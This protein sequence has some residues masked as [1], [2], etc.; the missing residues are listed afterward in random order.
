MRPQKEYEEVN[1]RLTRE[2]SRLRDAHDRLK[3]KKK[4]T[5]EE[6]GDMEALAAKADRA[7]KAVADFKEQHPEMQRKPRDAGNGWTR[8]TSDVEEHARQIGAE[9]RDIVDGA[10]L[11]NHVSSPA[12]RAW[13]QLGDKFG[14]VLNHRSSKGSD[15]FLKHATAA[16][17]G[18]I[19]DWSW[20]ETDKPAVRG[21]TK[22]NVRFQLQV[23][24]N[25][26]RTGGRDVTAESTE[27]LKQRFNLRE[28]QSGNWVLRD[29]NSAKFH[30]EQ[31]AAAFA[32]LADMVG[33][34]DAQ[35]SLNGRLA[36]AFGA[37]GHGNAG[38]GGAARAHYEPVQRVINLT[39]MGG[40]GTLAHEWFH[41]LDN[42]LVEAVGGDAGTDDFLTESQ[43]KLPPGDLRDA[44][45]GLHEALTSG[46]RRVA[47]EITYTGEDHRAARRNIVRDHIPEHSRDYGMPAP[48]KLIRDAANVHDA[49]QAVDTYFADLQSRRPSR[50][51][52]TLR[53]QWRTLAAAH[54]HGEAHGGT[55]AVEAGPKMSAYQHAAVMLDKGAHGKYWSSPRELAARAFQS[56][57][58][59][60]L[61]A[62]GRRNDYL[63][64]KADNKYYKMFGEKPFPEGAERKRLNAAFD[65]LM[66]AISAADMLSKALAAVVARKPRVV[67]FFKAKRPGT[68]DRMGD[69][70]DVPVQVATYT[71]KDGTVVTAHTETRKKRVEAPRMAQEPRAQASESRE[72]RYALVNR[73]AMLGTVPKGFAR[74]DPRPG[75]AEDHNDVARHGV[76]VYDHP[77]SE[78]EV[79]DF[80]LRH[81][82]DG[83]DRA[84][85][86]AEIADKIKADAGDDLGGTVEYMGEDKDVLH[87]TV[88]QYLGRDVSVGDVRAFSASVLGLLKVGPEAGREKGNGDP[89]VLM[90]LAGD[91]YQAAIEAQFGP[92][93]NRWDYPSSAYNAATR[94]AQA[95]FQ[96]AS[97]RF[98]DASE[99]RRAAASAIDERRLA[100]ETPV[101]K[102]MPI[103]FLKSA[104][105]VCIDRAE[106]DREHKRL[107]AVLRSPDHDDDLEEADDQ[108]AELAATRKRRKRQRR[109]EVSA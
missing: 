87:D 21:A 50:K 77:L 72:Y 36:L 41:A 80:E 68:A 29:V 44:F 45:A 28:V 11:R 30:T 91:A 109:A 42:L 103:L 57:A 96:V 46:E 62:Q 38:F 104:P 101:T 75:D 5:A 65:R 106:F 105:K 59:D 54:H 18:R 49:V 43:S 97:D 90:Q 64:A 93:A 13:N 27:A 25:Y 17:N 24:D 86:A 108:A 100:R 81:L 6:D 60:K 48:A 99:Q 79:K 98:W 34:K 15:A 39:K 2:A 71:K 20:A 40:G 92:K 14:R 61:A 70:F 58:E 94:A 23:A 73:P 31:T 26:Q 33:A 37:R 52:E 74:I 9:M 7:W 1:A 19:T 55:V 51:N 12:C 56:W 3:Y 82:V 84:A 102:S 89:Q 88:Q 66:G 67:L 83:T 32:D 22:E 107:V 63:S 47:R 85:L 53:K 69:L 16:T 10:R 78:K 76:V 35:I 8:F 4:R 95:A